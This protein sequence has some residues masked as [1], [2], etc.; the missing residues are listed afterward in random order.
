[1]SL[2]SHTLKMLPTQLTL[3]EIGGIANHVIR[4]RPNCLIIE[5]SLKIVIAFI[6]KVRPYAHGAVLEANTQIRLKQVTLGTHD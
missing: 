4:K 5:V 2:P 3:Q 6:K 1:M